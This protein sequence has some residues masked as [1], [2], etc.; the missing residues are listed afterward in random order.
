MKKIILG[1]L[2]MLAAPAARASWSAYYTGEY[3]SP[4]AD[5]LALS[6]NVTYIDITNPASPTP[7]QG[8]NWLAN[9]TQNNGYISVPLAP[10]PGAQGNIAFYF[11]TASTYQ[12]DYDLFVAY[13]SQGIVLLKINYSSFTGLVSVYFGSALVLTNAI[14]LNLNTSYTIQLSYSAT[15]ATLA[16]NGVDVTTAATLNLVNAT[17]AYALGDPIQGSVPGA[18]SLYMDGLAFSNASGDSFPPAIPTPTATPSNT[19]NYT[20]T[21]TPTVTKTATKTSTPTDT[22]TAT[23]TATPTASPT[24][25]VTPTYTPTASPSFSPS[26]SDTPTTFPTAILTPVPTPNYLLLWQH[27]AISS[28]WGTSGFPPLYVALVTFTVTPT[29]TPTFTRTDTPTMTPT[30]TPTA[31]P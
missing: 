13:N 31:T 19:P 28:G 27:V 25:T 9:P 7:P 8:S 12:E 2:L 6:P 17:S 29:I 24:D 18:T 21:D 5:A 4:T 30:A 15:G 1:L 14:P 3:P 23:P 10:I 26:P 22:Y 16:V 11:R 20:A